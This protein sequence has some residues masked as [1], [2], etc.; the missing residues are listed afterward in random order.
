MRPEDKIND[1]LPPITESVYSFRN[2]PKIPPEYSLSPMQ[3][4][5][6][7]RG[8]LISADIVYIYSKFHM[9]FIS[10]ISFGV[11]QILSHLFVIQETLKL[12]KLSKFSPNKK[13]FAWLC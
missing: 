8:T 12:P 11:F 7:T 10:F 13:G 9:N 2:A 1:V 5:N 4:R 6:G 3:L